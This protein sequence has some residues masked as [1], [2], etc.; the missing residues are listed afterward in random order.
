MPKIT[1]TFTETNQPSSFAVQEFNQ[2]VHQLLK[3]PRY[4]RA[5]KEHNF[6]ETAHNTQT[7][8]KS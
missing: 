6:P 1:Y 3:N 8:V 7:S 5:K 4:A 2:H